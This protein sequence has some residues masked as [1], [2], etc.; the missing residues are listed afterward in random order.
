MEASLPLPI[1][2]AKITGLLSALLNVTILLSE[3]PRHCTVG[4]K[5]DALKIHVLVKELRTNL[6]L[7]RWTC[8]YKRCPCKLLPVAFG[9]WHRGTWTSVL[10]AQVDVCICCALACCL[11]DSFTTTPITA[12]KKGRDLDPC[13]HPAEVVLAGFTGRT[14]GWEEWRSLSSFKTN[15]SNFKVPMIQ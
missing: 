8:S 12:C 2:K 7:F 6:C 4:V 13:R 1:A 10:R 11:I 14:L 15:L 5:G 9:I 3:K